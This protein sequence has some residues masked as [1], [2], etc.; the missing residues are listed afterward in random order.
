M[1]S[2]FSLLFFSS[3]L[4]NSILPT[5]TVLMRNSVFWYLLQYEA[6]HL[7]FRIFAAAHLGQRWICKSVVAYL[8]KHINYSI[9]LF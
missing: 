9:K 1:K 2:Y 4:M 8:K 7:I 5:E 3:S 6:A